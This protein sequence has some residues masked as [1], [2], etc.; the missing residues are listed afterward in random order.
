MK[1]L[2]TLL[3]AVAFIPAWSQKE[4]DP[5]VSCITYWIKG[6]TKI[7][8]IVHEKTTNSKDNKHIL[9]TYEA[10]VT[11]LD[12]TAED[13]T[14]KWVFHNPAL[15]GRELPALSQPLPVF[16]G[17]QMIFRISSVG[18]FIELLNWEEVRDSYVHLM[19]LSLPEKMDSAMTASVNNAKALFSTRESVEAA[20]IREIQLFHRPYGYKFT[21]LKVSENT[22]ISNPFGGNPLPAVQTYQV[23]E[24]DSRQDRYTLVVQ[25]KIDSNSLQLV[26]DDSSEYQFISSSGWIR[27]LYYL[28]RAG[29]A[30]LQQS[31]AYTITLKD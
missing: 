29:S 17:M 7:Y 11:V 2:V 1:L 10:H 8:S 6:E 31:D 22:Q 28:R 24:L 27:R 20:L 23:T 15:P 30:A 4:Q 14:I 9:F 25:Q 12:S 19:E 16:E 13:F 3:L 26:I 21:T 18:T 5:S